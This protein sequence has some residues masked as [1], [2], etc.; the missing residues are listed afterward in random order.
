MAIGFLQS[1]SEDEIFLT[2]ETTPGGGISARLEKDHPEQT[3]L[4][5]R[6]NNPFTLSIMK[7]AWEN[8]RDRDV[9]VPSP[10]I[11][12]LYIKFSPTS[13]EEVAALSE[14]D[15]MLYDY[16][17]EYEVLE[18]GDYYIKPDYEKNIFPELYAIVNPDFQFDGL[19][20]EIVEQLHIP[21]F[22]SPLTEEAF[23]L[24][25]NDYEEY[26]RLTTD[27]YADDNPGNYDPQV[28]SGGSGGGSGSGSGGNE[29]SSFITNDWGCEVFRDSRRPGGCVKVED[30]RLGLEGLRNV[31]VI[32]K[33]TWFTEDE[34]WTTSEGCFRINKRYAN[35]AWMWIKFKSNRV[36]IR[37][38]YFSNVKD[39]A[40]V[41]RNTFN[42]INIEYW[43]AVDDIRSTQNRYWVAATLNNALY[44]FDEYAL[45]EGILPPHQD[46]KITIR[47]GGAFY[48]APTFDKMSFQDTYSSFP[49]WVQWL[50]PYVVGVIP[51]S[52]LI[53]YAPD[54]AIGYTD[55]QN[56]FGFESDQFK[57]TIYHE[58]AHVSFMRQVGGDFW[59]DLVRAEINAGG[60]GT[61]DGP[62][63]DIISITESWA[64][65]IGHTFA[66]R[67][68]GGNNTI[69]DDW[70]RRI[71][72]T[73]N[74]RIG[75]IPAGLYHDL[76]DVIEIDERADIIDNVSGFTL[77]QLYTSLNQNT[78]SIPTYRQSLD[79]SFLSG[80]GNTVLEMDELFNSY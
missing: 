21:P 10:D 34:V 30:T 42:N 5:E 57:N 67:K 11:S 53:A 33:D 15:E 37:H 44:E 2:E 1:C 46:L 32:M 58:Y 52:V 3:R 25:G 59:S 12:R 51:S 18:M 16:P 47:S 17:L 56:D 35:R 60:W 48:A 40:G 63:A 55:L 24:T 4:G 7:Q 19:S 13:I 65:F 50:M 23:R 54:V 77:N 27:P 74:L 62:D 61:A 72:R 70:E 49:G 29:P 6:R 64:E 28:P 9:N 22:D 71:E 68:Y 45:E 14:L 31:K 80:T 36:H 39:Y 75:F 38:G 41:I 69:N 20:Y 8:L 73:R 26:A 79:N 78:R 66:H 76:V 43:R